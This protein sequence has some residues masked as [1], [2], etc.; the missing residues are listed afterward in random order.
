MRELMAATPVIDTALASLTHDPSRP[1]VTGYTADGRTE[2]SGTVLRN[3]ASKVAGLL[4]DEL[5]A[6]PGDEVLVTTPAHWQ[7]AGILLGAWWA[8]MSVT[9]TEGPDVVAAFVPPGG[10]AVCDEIFVV[11]GHPLGLG[12]TGLPPH[13]RDYTSSVLGQAD[14]FTARTATP[15]ARALRSGSTVIPAATLHGAMT[16]PSGIVPGQRVLTAGEWSFDGAVPGV[17][18]LLLRPLSTG[19]SV[20]HS[21][22]LDPAG[23]GDAWAHR[24]EVEKADVTIGVDVAG[25]PRLG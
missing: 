17:V 3:W 21:T 10:D 6:A 5:G 15:A 7:T 18:R 14:R 24:A 9:D 1:R 22:D 13:Q 11:S 16:A 20:I 2:L 23:D 19:A 12:L 25:L 4:L 8:G